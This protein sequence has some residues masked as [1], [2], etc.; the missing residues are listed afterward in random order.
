LLAIIVDGANF[1]ESPALKR[2]PAGNVARVSGRQ[3]PLTETA[4]DLVSSN[5]H[6]VARK[7]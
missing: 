7:R 5:P 4:P 6:S 1:A 2:Q 3:E